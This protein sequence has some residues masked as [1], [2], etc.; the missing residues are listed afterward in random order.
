MNELLNIKGVGLKTLKLLNNLNIFTIDDLISYIPY[1]FNII[2]KTDLNENKSVVDV[3][4]QS[5]PVLSYFKRNMNRLSF[6]ALYNSK[7]IKVT[8][9]NRAFLKEHLAMN[10]T[11]VIIGKYN[12]KQ[13]TF[14][15]SDII[16]E[17]F[18]KPKIVP[19]YHLTSGINQKKMNLLIN[20]A[21]N[22][23]VELEEYIPENIKNKYSFIDKYELLKVVNNPQEEE[24]IK[25]SIIQLKY[26]E[27]F[28]FMLKIRY[29]KQ[30]RSLEKENYSK[31]VDINKAEVIRNRLPFELT[32][33]QEKALQEIVDDLNSSIRMNRLLQGDVGSGK[34]IVAFLSMFIMKESG[35]QSAMMA[36][37]EVLAKQHFE[38]AKKLFK[39][40]NINVALLTG[41]TSKKEKED[42]YNK[43]LNKKID[44][45]I[46]THSLINKDLYFNN[47]GLVIADEQQRFGVSQRTMLKRK[48][49]N[50]EVLYLS[51]TPI[52]RT[53]ALTIYGDMDV[54]SIKTM[55]KGRKQIITK[56][57]KEEDIKEVLLKVKE[58]LDNNHQGYI[59]APMIEDDEESSYENVV[60]LKTKFSK[61][62]KG[63][64]IEIMHGKQKPNVKE[65]IMNDF[66]NNKIKIL[67]STTV[68]EVGIDVKNATFMVIFNA[69]KFGLSTLHQLRGRIGR[70][71]LEAYCYLISNSDTKR[72]SIMEQ[73]TD[74]YKISEEDFIMRGQGDLFGTAQSGEEVFKIANIRRDYKILLKVKE[75]IDEIMQ[76]KQEE[77]NLL[78]NRVLKN[79]YIAKNTNY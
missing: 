78:I 46:G 51:A 65:K 35:Y 30:R 76:L 48:G 19:I 31:N 22:T 12:I 34:T 2:T 23:K 66:I 5:V 18:N 15:C 1:K 25:R 20:S 39:D 56:V 68:I 38:N 61:A 29:L 50:I 14:L 57:L 3:K 21:L 6:N 69:E 44:I 63:I 16:F 60:R 75:D 72:L 27:L 36:P 52:P 32:N 33:D 54:S 28:I 8:I 45:V 37:T 41:S 64:P 11:I 55:P 26:E 13:N 59:V 73:E 43:L 49:E 47:L 42:I 40:L 79:N 10:N 4:V 77:K 9:F 71:N 7:L 74:G 53:Y 58:E 62:F 70:S 67:I 17:D 24:I